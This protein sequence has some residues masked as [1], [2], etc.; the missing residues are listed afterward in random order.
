MPALHD[1]DAAAAHQI[2]G[3]Q[4]VDAL[5]LELDRALGDVAALGLDEIGDRLQRGRLARAVGAEQGDDAALPHFQRHAL[6]HQDDVVVDDLDVLD[7]EDRPWPAAGAAAGL[8]GDTLSAP[9]DSFRGSGRRQ[10]PP[11]RDCVS[12]RAALSFPWRS[13]AA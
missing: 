12:D 8:A 9:L 11:P 4:P 5:A 7:R 13:R 6:E 2:V 1:L 10:P 3:R